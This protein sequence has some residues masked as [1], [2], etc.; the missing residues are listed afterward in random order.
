LLAESNQ[1]LA[2][3]GLL[4]EAVLAESRAGLKLA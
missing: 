3:Q 4:S 1:K 2:S